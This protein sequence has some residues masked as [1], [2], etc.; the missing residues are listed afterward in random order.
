VGPPKEALVTIRA[1]LGKLRAT[2]A[3]P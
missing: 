2:V 1:E 3:E